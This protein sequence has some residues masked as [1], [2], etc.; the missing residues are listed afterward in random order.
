M[1]KT[2]TSLRETTKQ[3]LN[4]LKKVTRIWERELWGDC[5]CDNCLA[6]F[7]V[8][9]LKCRSDTSDNNWWR[10]KDIRIFIENFWGKKET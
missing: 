10:M 3:L 5:K 4:E 7:L 8:R 9:Y 6:L 1:A 2:K